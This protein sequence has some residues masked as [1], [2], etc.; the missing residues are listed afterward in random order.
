[1]KPPLD[2]HPDESRFVTHLQHVGYT[3]SEDRDP[4][5]WRYASHALGP[6]LCFR[7]A[8]DILQ[9]HAEYSIGKDS[10]VP[11]EDLLQTANTL[12]GCQW[13]TR[14]TAVPPRD[15]GSTAAALRLQANIPLDMSDTELGECLYAWLR[16]S[17]HVERAVDRHQLQTLPNDIVPDCDDASSE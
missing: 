7:I 15:G 12:N 6:D 16:E 2:V 13:L 8:V 17:V 9:V 3:T 1:M 5:G 10:P 14:C 4:N 11:F